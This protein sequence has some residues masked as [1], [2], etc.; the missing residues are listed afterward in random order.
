[1]VELE[2][3]N[4]CARLALLLTIRTKY[5]HVHTYD[6]I[7]SDTVTW[8]DEEGGLG[9]FKEVFVRPCQCVLDHWFLGAELNCGWVYVRMCEDCELNTSMRLHSNPITFSLPTKIK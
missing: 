8:R 4:L 2:G 9:P 5:L 1:M 3:E 6:T 7:S